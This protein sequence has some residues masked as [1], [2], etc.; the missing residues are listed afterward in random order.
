[1]LISVTEDE[2][3][4]LTARRA[5]AK[6]GRTLQL[7]PTVESP[8]PELM[9]RLRELFGDEDMERDAGKWRNRINQWPRRVEALLMN[10]EAR[11]ADGQPVRRPSAYAEAMWRKYC[12]GPEPKPAHA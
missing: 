2:L 5:A 4:L 1:M 8:T 6:L 3:A 9:G 12:T 10:L 11:V 7:G